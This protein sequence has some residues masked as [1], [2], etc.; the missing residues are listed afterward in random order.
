MKNIWLMTSLIPL[1]MA[2]GSGEES[3][4]SDTADLKQ[5]DV[6][7][8]DG[9]TD[10]FIRSELNESDVRI[11]FG[12]ADVTSPDSG[13]QCAPGEG[14]FLDKCQ[15]NGDCLSGWCVE[16]MGE[17]VC[18]MA[19]QEDCPAGWACKPVGT[20]GPDIVY[21]C[22]SDYSNLC[23]PCVMSSDCKNVGGADDVCVSYG[24]EGNFCGGSCD[25]QQECPWGFTCKESETVDSVT[26][27]QCVADAGVCPCTG[28]SVQLGLWTRCGLSSEYGTC[29][30]MRICTEQGLSACDAAVPTQESCN[31]L[32]DD[33]DSEVDEPLLFE[34]KYLELC[35]DSNPCTADACKGEAGCQYVQLTEGE[36][37]DGDACTIGDHCQEGQC[38]GLPIACNDNNVCT[39]DV[40]DGLGGCTIEYNMAS[41]DDGDPCTV[42]DQCS[43]GAC[44]GYQVDCECQVNEDCAALEDGDLCNGT[45]FCNKK[46]LPYECAVDP[47]TIIECDPPDQNGSICLTTICNPQTGEC[48][49]APAW[50]GY[51]CDDQDLCTIGDVC[52][53]GQCISGVPVVCADNNVCT[54][55][56]CKTDSGCIFT[57]N[58]S[59]CNDADPCTTMD[60][61]KEGMCVGSDSLS[62]DDGNPCTTDSCDSDIGCFHAANQAGCDDND[63]CTVND[64]CFNGSCIS[65]GKMNCDDG[66]P[67][68]ED[69]CLPNGGCASNIKVAP[70]DDG[71]PCT[72][73]DQCINGLC[74]AGPPLNCNDDNPCTD[75]SCNEDGICIHDANNL[76]CDDGNK[77][78]TGDHCSAGICV[79]L[80]SL[81]CNDDNIC[82]TDTCNPAVG[83]VFSVNSVPCDDGDV[84]TT[85][86]T[87]T[88]GS[89][90]PQGTLV[91][92]DGNLCTDDSCNP[93]AGCMFE[94]NDVTCNDGNFC[95]IGDHCSG[96]W[97]VSGL[98]L[99][100]KDDD[101]CTDDECDP[102]VGCTHNNNVAFCNDGDL[103]TVLDI[104]KE[105]DCV[106]GQQLQCNDDN[107][108]TDNGCDPALGCTIVHNQDI[109]DDGVGC[110]IN[111]QCQDGL[112]KGASCEEVNQTCWQGQCVDHYCGDG[113]C[114]ADENTGNCA[115][116]CQPVLWME[117][118]EVEW[119]PV[120]YAHTDYK[121]SLAVATC[122]AAGLRLWRDEVGP[123]NS[124]DWVYDVNNSHNLGGHDIGYKVEQACTNGQETHT[125]TWVLFGQQWSDSIKETSG[126]SN[127]QNVT[128]MNKQ[129]H[130]DDFE[131]TASYTIVTP[132]SSSVSY[133]Q[134]EYSA[135]VQNL[136]Y[137]IVLC[138][139]RK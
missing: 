81:V 79:S 122:K 13:P 71:D 70:C 58:T 136:V 102:G 23:K 57:N 138:A 20:G 7:A 14:C 44:E 61:C 108:C 64:H 86:D 82:T 39:D 72:V 32:D 115:A 130:T 59:V 62:C 111:D 30:G 11:D 66:N 38:V 10:Q 15:Q 125:G 40:C 33:C 73:N 107:P 16:H 127:G 51:A 26:L 67:C 1:C 48:D 129:A 24:S 90:T 2:C 131:D 89:C 75:D 120:K 37:V 114:D 80:Q 47:G 94:P 77:C 9:A 132:N 42:A 5:P 106:G 101:P 6:A 45:L 98:W 22:V 36:C 135:T 110:T 4:V 63:E 54:D 35:D 100:C 116:D 31:G 91:C 103:C 76:D 17:G 74:M 93:G 21:I 28:K 123:S 43:Q 84:C 46:K 8:K 139:K 87:C 97:C 12:P 126:A 96:G 18:T 68:T 25:E 50:E 83:C 19:C 88:Q 55:D 113:A 29:D 133:V 99:A 85:G 112:C 137:G 118:S 104:C 95:T 60:A 3:L 109:C 117:S 128:I 69:L 49:D 65:D 41:C 27:F 119:F 105:G 53:Q 121:Q 124:P 92:D 52:Q 134:G 34:G 78:T 56:I